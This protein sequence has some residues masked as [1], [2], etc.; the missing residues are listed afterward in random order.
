MSNKVMTNKAV[1]DYIFLSLFIFGTGLGAATIMR[2]AIGVSAWDALTQSLSELSSIKIGTMAIVL[3]LICLAG[4]IILEKGKITIYTILQ[5]PMTFILGSVVN[6]IYYD[7]I[8]DMVL[9]NYLL[10]IVVYSIGQLIISACIG[11]IMSINRLVF[12]LEGLCM[13]ISEKT[14]IEFTKI[15]QAV[16]VIC[17]GLA[18]IIFLVFKTTPTIREGTIIGM[19]TFGP[20]VG[21]W[22]KV[23]KPILN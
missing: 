20:L 14:S 22:M 6:L 5:L 17:I 18:F 1:K 23:W 10:K 2:V 8:V 4:Q 9:N 11:G 19:L 16:D 15:R 7:L 12:P 21:L 13:V 3:N